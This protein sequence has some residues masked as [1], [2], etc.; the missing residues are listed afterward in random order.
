MKENISKYSIGA[1][2]KSGDFSLAMLLIHASIQNALLSHR[3][4]C[5]KKDTKH[6]LAFHATFY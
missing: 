6:Q 3:I 5:E 4:I 2:G 1:R